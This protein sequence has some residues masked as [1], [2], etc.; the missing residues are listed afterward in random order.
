MNMFLLTLFAC[1]DKTEDT[2]SIDTDVEETETEDTEDTDD[3]ENTED[4]DDTDDTDDTAP[5][6]IL[7]LIGTY[8]DSWGGTQTVTDETW[9]TGYGSLFHISQFDND[10]GSLIAQN[11]SGN[12]YNPD[13]FSKFEWTMNNEGL[14][15]CQSAFDAAT[16]ED[17]MN[18]TA[19]ATDLTAGCG[20]FGWTEL[21]NELDIS[22]SFL[23]SWGSTHSIDAFAWIIG[24]SSFHVL[25]S[26][27]DLEYL[28]AQ[29]DSGNGYNPDLFSKF[30]WTMDNEAWY[31]CQSAYNAATAEDAMDAAADATD[32][33]AGCG[34]FAWSSLTAE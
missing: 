11:D 3:T 21:R 23:D 22:G 9:L 5:P 27:N 14:Y 12:A 6:E 26:D 16:E 4:T 32:L 15:Y 13:L 24:S 31:Y 17:A 10:A 29:N 18:A 7:D 19:N 25:E 20:G 30:E 33:T 8:T 2:G 1:G 28:I 34:G